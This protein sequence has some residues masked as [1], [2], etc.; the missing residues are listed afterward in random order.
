VRARRAFTLIEL[1][2]VVGVLVAL[3]AIALPYGGQVL[4]RQAFEGS[5]D[6]AVAQAMSARAW[7]QREG[8][9]VELVIADDGTRIEA[10]AVDLLREAEDGADGIASVDGM[11]QALRGSRKAQR[12]K[13]EMEKRVAEVGARAGV[14]VD[15]GGGDG[16]AGFDAGFDTEI[17]EPWASVA[18]ERGVIASLE[19]PAAVDEREEFASDPGEERIA[20]FLPDGSAAAV[21]ELWISAGARVSRISIDPLLGEVRRSEPRR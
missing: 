3:A 21:R 8:R 6:G 5:A 1:L 9:V 16:G 15:A 4:E 12:L 20:L 7:A 14:E 17:A 19:R 18:L 11:E 13:R 10:R 2:V